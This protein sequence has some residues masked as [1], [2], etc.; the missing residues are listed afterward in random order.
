MPKTTVLEKL[1]LPYVKCRGYGH[2]WDWET[3]EGLQRN[4]R[5]KLVEF[6]EVLKCLRCD[7]RRYDTVT[8][9]SHELVKR[10]YARPIAY[11]LKKPGRTPRR[12]V[13]HEFALRR[14]LK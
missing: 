7:A 1:S 6:T 4:A 2:S 3:D 5:G 9:A 10:R 12:E 11:D 8:V 14:N 13:L